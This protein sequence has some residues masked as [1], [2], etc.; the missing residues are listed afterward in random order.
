MH[1]HAT[2][3]AALREEL[4]EEVRS[5]A[6]HDAAAVAEEGARLARKA[7]LEATSRTVESADSPASVIIEVA[8][9]ENVAAVVVGRTLRGDSVPWS[10]GSV[11]HRIVDHI[12]MPVVLV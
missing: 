7:G 5:A 8:A 3:V 6:R 2:S 1:V 10:L 9:Q 11:S 12:D 4:I